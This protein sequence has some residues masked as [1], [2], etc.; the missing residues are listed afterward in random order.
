MSG[1][2]GDTEVKETAAEIALAEV[3]AKKWQDYQADFIPLEN[4]YMEQVKKLDSANVQNR[5]AANA[6]ANVAS[7]MAGSGVGLQ[8]QS[9][10]RNLDP[11]SGSFKTKSGVLNTAIQ[12]SIDNAANNAKFGAENAY[13]Q[14]VGNVVAMGN[15]QETAAYNSM[16]QL[17]GQA[18]QQAINDARS[19]F[20][21]AQSEQEMVGSVVGGL[22]AYGLDYAKSGASV[23]S[24]NPFDGQTLNIP[25]QP[26]PTL[27]TRYAAQNAA[28][29]GLIGG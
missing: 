4:Q 6:G 18:S 26:F 15:G 7:Q 9:F 14:G 11:T 3:A 19:D 8:Q 2:G 12:K 10:A 1:G 27:D 29:P 28:Q 5:V 13:I 22:S 23:A 21:K 20:T 25:T 24:S 16:G 17:A